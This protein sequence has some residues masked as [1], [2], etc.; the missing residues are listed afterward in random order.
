MEGT[1]GPLDSGG[2]RASPC[3]PSKVKNLRS[4]RL[5]WGEGF[6]L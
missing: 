1:C 6:A 2:G 3:D 4:L 5:W